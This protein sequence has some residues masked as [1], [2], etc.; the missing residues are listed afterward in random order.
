MDPG[1]LGALGALLSG[2]DGDGGS[3]ALPGGLAGLMGGSA[4]GGASIAILT[5][6]GRG[7]VGTAITPNGQDGAFPLPMGFLQNLGG[8]VSRVPLPQEQDAAAAL[9]GIMSMMMEQMT[10]VAVQRSMEEQTPKVPPA[11]ERVRD[12]LPRV[13]VTKEDLLDST[14]SKCS[15]CLEDFQ[16]GSRATRMLCGHLFC[17]SCIREWLREANSC[18]VCRYEL[19]TDC[20]AFESGRRSRMSGRQIRL[21]RAELRM[22]RISELRRLMD[23]LG[24]SGE[25]CLEKAELLRHLEVAPDVVVEDENPQSHW[26]YEKEEL[27]NL[28]LPLLRNLL[29]RHKVPYSLD[30]DVS[31]EEERCAALKCFAESGWMKGSKDRPK[32]QEKTENP[33]PLATENCQGDETSQKETSKKDGQGNESVD[34]EVTEKVSEKEETTKQEER[35]QHAEQEKEKDKKQENDENDAEEPQI[36]DPENDSQGATSSGAPSRGPLRPSGPAPAVRRPL[37]SRSSAGLS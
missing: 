14:N 11:S 17:T 24:I 27:L 28:D 26:I 15:V 5:V 3:G 4:G 12:A 2:M 9:G 19:A 30:D 29:E 25:G 22:L 35:K 37:R 16:P 10:R 36:P 13:V 6:P 1:L 34:E 33:E 7:I 8:Q 23:A 21:K 20:E 31:E 18:P 32:A